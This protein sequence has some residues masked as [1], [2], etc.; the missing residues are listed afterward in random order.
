VEPVLGTGCQKCPVFFGYYCNIAASAPKTVLCA[1]CYPGLDG[2]LRRHFRCHCHWH[3]GVSRLPVHRRLDWT[4]GNIIEKFYRKLCRSGAHCKNN[5]RIVRQWMVK[6]IPT[7]IPDQG[8]K[9]RTKNL[10]K[11]GNNKRRRRKRGLKI[12]ASPKFQF[13]CNFGHRHHSSHTYYCTTPLSPDS[14]DQP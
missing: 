1:M 6:P 5:Q 14:P 4:F 11:V 2:E 12:F 8:K 9:I 10:E 3:S 7:H 13:C